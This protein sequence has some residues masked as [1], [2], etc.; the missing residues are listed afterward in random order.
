MI[1]MCRH[2]RADAWFPREEG[3]VLLAIHA[4]ADGPAVD[5]TRSYYR[6][7]R[8][9]TRGHAVAA[10]GSRN[11]RHGSLSARPIIPA[12]PFWVRTY[13]TSPQRSHSVRRPP[14]PSSTHS[15]SRCPRP[16]ATDTARSQSCLRPASPE[17][18]MDARLMTRP[19]DVHLADG[20]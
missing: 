10:G 15:W 12:R 6:E 14:A 3:A 4:A 1:E 18:P 7:V 19:A 2:C 13:A 9:A 17:A 16:D 20:A 8:G 11:G 5:W